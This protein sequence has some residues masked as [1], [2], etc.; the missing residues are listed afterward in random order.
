MSNKKST[1]KKSTKKETKAKVSPTPNLPDDGLET[2][3]V[4]A[5]WKNFSQKNNQ[6]Y[7][8]FV[9]EDNDRLP[10]FNKQVIEELGINPNDKLTKFDLPQ[11]VQVSIKETNN[12]RV[13]SGT[14]AGQPIQIQTP[15]KQSYSGKK[16]YSSNF[17][18]NTPKDSDEIARMN[19]LR[20]AVEFL[21]YQK[22][23]TLEKLEGLAEHF[24]SYIKKGAWK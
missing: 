3:S 11:T 17:Q 12:S 4:T 7:W 9:T 14:K 16:N 23:P 24:Y 18:K 10:C 13:I 1:K 20:T 15:S 2:I 5:I 6:P 8:L 19:A 22:T 21:A